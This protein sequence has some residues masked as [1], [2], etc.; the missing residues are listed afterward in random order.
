MIKGKVLFVGQ[1]YYHTWYLSRELRK[2]G[3]KADVL[4]W[5]SNEDNRKNLY[6][7]EDFYFSNNSFSDIEFQYKFFLKAINEYDIFHFS[8]AHGMTF[9][10]NLHNKLK[11][12]L[13]DFWDVKM[14]KQL[15]K[16]VVHSV[17]GCNDGVSKTS[18][19]KW[20]GYESVCQSCAWLE[21]DSVCSDEKNL[22]FAKVRNELA[23]LIILNDGNK[24]DY[25]KDEKVKVIPEFYCLDEDIWNGDLLIPAN[26]KLT[27]PSDTIK[28]YHSIGN[29]ELRTNVKDSKNIKSTHIY[30]DVIER[31]KKEGY[32]IELIFFKDI[33]NKN[34]KYYQMQAD[35]VVD[36]LT[37]GWYGANI[38][39]SMMLGK[40]CI[41]FLRP[42]WE[43]IIE[44]DA[45]NHFIENPIISA[46]PENIYEKLK[47]LIEN[48]S[49]REEV[50]KK[51]RAFAKKWHS[52][53]IAAKKFD[54]IY[55]N[56]LKTNN[57]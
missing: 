40:P 11:D 36:M 24:T 1:S 27:T 51:S 2:L 47:Y 37:F 42:E 46:T 49:Y 15:G 28:I 39:E 8:N 7:G 17:S 21:N 26:Y 45:P 4:N 43:D 33:P 5:D 13:G 35:I 34:I 41:C 19:G 18:F 32:K 29:Y 55:L 9:S 38:R 20:E 25:N 50:G 56:L 54:E 30:L 12:T 48:K 16:V 22:N 44:K 23:D 3:W 14:L 57:V 52:S 10:Y 53:K 6:H 31:L